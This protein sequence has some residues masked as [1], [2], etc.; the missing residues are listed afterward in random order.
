MPKMVTGTET[1][2]DP[3][4]GRDKDDPSNLRFDIWET[5]WD[6]F[7]DKPLLGASPRNIQEYCKENYPNSIL[8]TSSRN[9][10]NV[11]STY[12]SLLS[13]TGVLGSVTMIG[14]MAIGVLTIIKVLLKMKKD[15]MITVGC[16]LAMVAIAFEGV[17]Y[18]DIVFTNLTSCVIFWCAF[19][20]GLYFVRDEAA[21][22]HKLSIEAVYKAIFK[23][24]KAV[25]G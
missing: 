10:T 1:P 23:R 11:H 15:Y 22:M 4:G 14:F 12:V 19:G 20:Y 13:S 3:N 17:F 18:L 9:Y 5:G 6:V 8:V 24:G 7:T 25:E 21:L 16:L 2:S